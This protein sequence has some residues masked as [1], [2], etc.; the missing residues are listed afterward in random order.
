MRARL[1]LASLGLLVVGGCGDEAGVSAGSCDE[2]V[3]ERVDANS[4]H[5]LPGADTPSYLSDP[6]TS[7]PH[8]ASRPTTGVQDEPIDDVQQVSTLEVGIVIVQHR[9]LDADELAAVEVLADRTTAVAPDPDLDAR[10]VAT[11]WGLSM[12]CDGV[13]PD[14][15]EQFADTALEQFSG[16]GHAADPTS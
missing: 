16:A 4:T 12:R 9:D 5:L 8:V 11:A 1:A 3:H 10:V 14:A 6:P 7:G 15:L 13:D 2:I